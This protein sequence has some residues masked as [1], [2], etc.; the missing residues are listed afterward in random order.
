MYW[1]LYNNP[2]S[3]NGLEEG[4]DDFAT[5]KN[6]FGKYG[7]NGPMPPTTTVRT[8]TS[9]GCWRWT[10]SP[11]YWTEC[12]RRNCWIRWNPTHWA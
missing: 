8:I 11:T 2:G 6:N 12:S 10:W 3:A 1:V 4:T 7:Y 5:G 9:S